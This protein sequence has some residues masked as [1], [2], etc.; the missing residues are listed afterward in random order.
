MF[1]TLHVVGSRN[2]LAP[3][4]GDD[5]TDTLVDDP[6]RRTAEV[7]HRTQAAID[8]LHRT[9]ALAKKPKAD[10]VV[11]SIQADTWPGSTTDGFSAIIQ[12]MA[13]L[14][15]DFGKPVLV[16]QGDSHV[17]R[18]DQPLATGDTV[19]GVTQQVPNLTRIVVQ[20]ETTSEWLKLRVDPKGP[21]LFTWERKFR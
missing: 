7:D 21:T 15:L 3:W 11:L 19:H 2:G 8:W 12:R 18:T 14:A 13:T 1:S 17:Y 9:F 20:G 16:I 4:F 10:G 6:I 5:T